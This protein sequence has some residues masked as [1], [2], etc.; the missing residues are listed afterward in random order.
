MVLKV[1]Y[2]GTCIKSPWEDLQ[3]L[4]LLLESVL[5]IKS[6][7]STQARNW[8]IWTRA[9]EALEKNNTSIPRE[10]AVSRTVDADSPAPTLVEA[11]F[12]VRR[13]SE[14]LLVRQSC[15]HISP[16]LPWVIGRSSKYILKAVEEEEEGEI[17]KED[18]ECCSCFCFYHCWGNHLFIQLI[19]TKYLLC[20]RRCQGGET[21]KE[22]LDMDPELKALTEWCIEDEVNT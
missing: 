22:E 5:K 16:N 17:E 18:K 3:L 20:T 6:G 13:V 10:P 2:V 21:A 4:S 14:T 1:Q 12:V 8:H 11:S 19:F 9:D 7:V 15:L